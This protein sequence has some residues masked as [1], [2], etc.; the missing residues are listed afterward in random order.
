M[1]TIRLFVD[2]PLAIGDSIELDERAHR[3]AIQVL[4]LRPGA[5]ITLFNGRGGEYQAEITLADKRRSAADIKAF[6]D[7]DTRP[8]LSVTLVQGISRGER[9]DFSLQKATELGVSRVVPII[10]RHSQARGDARRLANRHSHW[11][12]VI[13]SACEQCGRNELPILEPA[14]TLDQW[15]SDERD[16]YG[17]EICGLV[18]DPQADHGL[19]NMSPR[20]PVHLLIGP[21]GGLD[22]AEIALARRHGMHPVSLGPRI[23]RTETAGI[24]ALAVIQAL[25]GDLC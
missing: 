9:M 20:G 13:I 12:G 2:Q 16:A 3:H 5:R 15:L 24:A 14:T 4:R 25:W 11:Q 7:R 21:E 19:G 8:A 22:D 10:T 1:R 23:L 17:G 6:E 18:L